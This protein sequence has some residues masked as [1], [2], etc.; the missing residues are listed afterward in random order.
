MKRFKTVLLVVI[1]FTALS[2]LIVVKTKK[3]KLLNSKQA[4]IYLDEGDFENAIE[5]YN[6]I[7]DIKKIILYVKN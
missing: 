4:L 1:I 7:L 3:N 6:K 5:L 2:L